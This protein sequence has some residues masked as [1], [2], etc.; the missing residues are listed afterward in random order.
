MKKVSFLEVSEHQSCIDCSRPLKKNVLVRK[1]K[2]VN[3]CYVCFLL[4]SGVKEIRKFKT[5]G[6]GVKELKKIIVLA[7]KQKQNRLSYRDVVNVK[8][9]NKN[10]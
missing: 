9:I 3:R 8:N 1:V 5:N 2:L 10:R 4:D 6:S 7:N